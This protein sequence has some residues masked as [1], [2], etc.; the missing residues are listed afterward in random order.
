MPGTPLSGSA[1]A[2][3]GALA[4]EAAAVAPGSLMPAEGVVVFLRVNTTQQPRF[5]SLAFFQFSSVQFSSV[6]YSKFSLGLFACLFV[7]VCLFLFLFDC[8]CL[9]FFV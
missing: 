2:A 4:D 1:S 5:P 8:F 7:F 3:L 6:H 9:F